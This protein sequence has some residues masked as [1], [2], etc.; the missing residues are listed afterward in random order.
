[1][2]RGD[3]MRRWVLLPILMVTLAGGACEAPR[4]AAIVP[5]YADDHDERLQRA[6]ADLEAGNHEAAWFRLWDLALEG[7]TA[8]QVNLAQL[9]RDGLGVPADPQTARRWIERAATSGHPLAQYR[10]GEFYEEEAQS[11]VELQAAE[12]WYKRAAEQ[13]L[14]GAEEAAQRLQLRLRRTPDS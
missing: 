12:L 9:Y 5:A 1:M 10:L 3:D 6:L 13:G 8:A 4:P 11:R 14:T 2:F 7:N